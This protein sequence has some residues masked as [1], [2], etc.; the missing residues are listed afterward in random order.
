MG[1]AASS[2]GAAAAAL[3][4]SPRRSS[5]QGAVHAPLLFLRRFVLFCA[6]FSAVLPGVDAQGDFWSKLVRNIERSSNLNTQPGSTLE[7]DV[8][9]LIFFFN[10]TCTEA[11]E[12]AGSNNPYRG[13]FSLKSQWLQQQGWESIVR[14]HSS[15]Q[16]Q[17]RSLYM[18]G[19]EELAA[20]HCFWNI[21]SLEEGTVNGTRYPNPR[22]TIIEDCCEKL[23]RPVLQIRDA[24][25]AT[26]RGVGRAYRAATA[27]I[28]QGSNQLLADDVAYVPKLDCTSPENI[29]DPVRRSRVYTL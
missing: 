22:W 13:A 20:K 29:F 5:C 12:N 10:N 1:R 21:Q 4:I 9:A 3:S 25:W 17:C 16:V 18:E 2:G 7:R 24:V 19:G 28:A 6:V 27:A 11:V 14:A 26:T 23:Q 15:V 8:Q